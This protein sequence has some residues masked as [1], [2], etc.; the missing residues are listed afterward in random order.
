MN[1]A[2]AHAG[3]YTMK[4]HSDGIATAAVTSLVLSMPGPYAP[5]TSSAGGGT[6]R[7][8]GLR[9]SQSEAALALL[10]EAEGL[11]ELALAEI[12]PQRLGNVD[13]RVR[14]LPEVEVAHPH[15]AARA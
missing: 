15:L 1:A 3:A 13:L 7:G 14:E 11:H 6:Q 12:G 8:L 9:G 10:V 4:S 5:T 2:K